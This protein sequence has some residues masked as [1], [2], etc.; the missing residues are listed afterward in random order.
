MVGDHTLGDAGG[1]PGA[2]WSPRKNYEYQLGLMFFSDLEDQK[3]EQAM[4][5]IDIFTKYAVAVPIKRKN[6]R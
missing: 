1:S 6:R 5:R 3:F 2:L 4:L